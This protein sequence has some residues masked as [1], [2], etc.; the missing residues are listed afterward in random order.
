MKTC[1]L[2]FGSRVAA[3]ALCCFATPTSAGAGDVKPQTFKDFDCYVHAA[4]ARMNGRKAFLLMEGDTP[5]QQQLRTVEANGPNP[6]KI[7]GGQLYDFVG[8][9]FIPGATVDRTVRMLQ[10]YDHRAQYFADVIATSKLQ[11][12]TGDDHFGFA[13]RLKEPGV[14]DSD[15]DVVWERIDAHR[16]RCRSYSTKMQEVGKAK[17]YL[18][19]LYSYWRFAETEKGVFVEGQTI[20]LSGEFGSITRALGSMMGISPEKALRRTLTSMRESV[21]NQKF[22]FALPP[23]GLP[24]CAAP[25][26]PAECTATPAR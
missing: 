16:W 26:R 3:V 12:R 20:T 17:G 4:E 9:V 6:H 22:E 2:S 23:A 11:C 18:L 21:L 14:I 7:S 8:V 5:V 15:N 25:Y 1:T 24:A 10:D 19:R 13:M